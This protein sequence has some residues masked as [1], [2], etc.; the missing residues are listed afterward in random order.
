MGEE[1]EQRPTDVPDA[2][3]VP[4]PDSP[5][6]FGIFGESEKLDRAGRVALNPTEEEPAN[7]VRTGG[8][9]RSRE[10]DEDATG[11]TEAREGKANGGI[12]SECGVEKRCPSRAE[13]ISGG[14]FRNMPVADEDVAT[15]SV[16]SWA[17]NWRKRFLRWY[18][19]FCL[20]RLFRT[21]PF[22]RLSFSESSASGFVKM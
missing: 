16:I 10:A 4:I 2:A 12:E 8:G 15:F 7:G 1:I 17:C 6:K 5:P 13:P 20:I 14:G 11:A 19:R 3:V 21:A 9:A 22:R 18:E